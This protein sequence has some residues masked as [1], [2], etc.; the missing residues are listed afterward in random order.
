M[1]HDLLH[2]KSIL[3]VFPLKIHEE[4]TP[5]SSCVLESS[6]TFD[7]QKFFHICASR[8]LFRNPKT[9]K[10]RKTRLVFMQE[11]KKLNINKYLHKLQP[12]IIAI[13]GTYPTPSKQGKKKT[14]KFTPY[15]VN[16][17]LKIP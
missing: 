6:T 8:K 1:V 10:I 16:R 9:L 14:L 4:T 13:K 5:Q 3:N 11:S 17:H 15:G 12:S 2:F 7:R